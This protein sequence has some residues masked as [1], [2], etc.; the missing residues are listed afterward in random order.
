MP[1]RLRL[2]V[3]KYFSSRR[4]PDIFL[5]TEIPVSSVLP[6]D[7]IP[8]GMSSHNSCHFFTSGPSLIRTIIFNVLP[9]RTKI[10]M[11]FTTPAVSESR[12]T[13]AYC[14]LSPA[15]ISLTPMTFIK[16]RYIRLLVAAKYPSLLSV[17]FA[18]HTTCSMA[19]APFSSIF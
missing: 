12:C 3:T 7:V 10:A 14:Q 6:T 19:A 9:F 4:H 11:L 17:P 15:F 13:T 2:G 16:L 1:F 5:A 18:A 8:T